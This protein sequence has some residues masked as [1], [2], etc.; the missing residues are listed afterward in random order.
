LLSAALNAEVAAIVLLRAATLTT[1]GEKVEATAIVR[2]IARE[3]KAVKVEA[4]AIVLANA[5]T[6]TSEGS[7]VEVTSTRT[8]KSI[9]ADEI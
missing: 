5:E 9:G 7:N 6:S 1:A 3:T 2:S 8:G 4:T